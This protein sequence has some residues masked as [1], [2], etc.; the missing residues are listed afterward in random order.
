ML[1]F[2]VLGILHDSPMHGYELR[3]QLRELL[4]SARAF[5][6]GSLYPTL[7]RLQRTGL[8][9]ERVP[10]PGDERSGR[11]RK[12]YELTAEGKER[13][14]ELTE[15]TGPGSCE[16][17]SFCVHM[18][19]FARTSAAA[20]M[21]ILEGRRRRVEQRREGL[22]SA[23]TRAGAQIDRYTREL[24]RQGL[25]ASEREVRWLNELIAHERA[26]QGTEKKENR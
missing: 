1:E 3:K 11:V 15:D 21:R 17:E 16:D 6:F 24:H 8:I 23:L 4:G 2:A 19:F 13:F 25:D 5:S 26:E 20:R 18:V 9:A 14:N 7:R 10:D 12:V 22:R